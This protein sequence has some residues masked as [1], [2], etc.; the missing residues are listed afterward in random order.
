MVN[1]SAGGFAIETTDKEITSMK[2]TKLRVTVERFPLLKD[3][4]LEGLVLR[5]TENDGKYI[6]GCRMMED[7]KD[8][9]NYVERN[10]VGE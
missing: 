7:D 1:L 4:N 2:G 9:L 8:I 10:Y 6:I 5:I 3:K